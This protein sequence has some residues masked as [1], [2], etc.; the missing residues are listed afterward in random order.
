MQMV[1]VEQTKTMVVNPV[2]VD[3]QEDL[4]VVEEHT[5]VN[6]VDHLEQQTLVVVEVAVGVLLV[7]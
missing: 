1:V 4:L 3:W 2:L 7:D 5:L 6:Q